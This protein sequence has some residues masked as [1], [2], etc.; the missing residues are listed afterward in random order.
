MSTG[1]RADA[2]SEFRTFLKNNMPQITSNTSIYIRFSFLVVILIAILFVVLK[3][4][5]PSARTL[6]YDVEENALLVSR[7]A[8]EDNEEDENHHCSVF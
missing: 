5:N 8:P 2:N 1:K 4:F 3:A 6:S 7:P